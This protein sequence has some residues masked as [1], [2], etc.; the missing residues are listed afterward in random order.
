[1]LFVPAAGWAVKKAPAVVSRITNS[2]TFGSSPASVSLPGSIVS[3]NLLILAIGFFNPPSPISLTTP[4][5]WTLLT[6]LG[7]GSATTQV[8]Y[9]F[10]KTASGSEGATVSISFSPTSSP[11][12]WGAVAYQISGWS[13][14]PQ[15][16]TFATASSTAPNPPS[17]TPTGALSLA[18]AIAGGGGG[19]SVTQ[20]I[21]SYPSGYS[22]GQLGANA[23]AT[24]RG[25][26][27]SAEATIS[28][29]S[30]VDPGAFTIGT[31]QAWWAQTVIIS[32]A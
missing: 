15:Y 1:M 27:G 28:G 11:Y 21:S 26:C 12:A 16:G 19:G 14:T 25:W 8:G 7:G 24:N 32:G 31:S 4:S 6:S 30:A 23:S 20:T 10:Y 22:N 2:G 29:T 3:G 18:L 9:I 5:G 13:G 17:V